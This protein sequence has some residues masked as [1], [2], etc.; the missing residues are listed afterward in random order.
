MSRA[1]IFVA[2]VV[3]DFSH[4]HHSDRPEVDCDSRDMLVA[5]SIAT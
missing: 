4:V 1:H 3:V 2:D 5:K